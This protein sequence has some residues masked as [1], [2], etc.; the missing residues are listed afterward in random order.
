M[1]KILPIKGFSE[2]Y[3]ADSGYVYSRKIYN[4]PNGRIKK[5]KTLKHNKGY[6]IIVLCKDGKTKIRYVHRLVAEAFIPNPEN[7]PEINHKNGI[8]SDNRVENLEWATHS[9]NQIHRYRVLKH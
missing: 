8:K 5:I 1:S 7:K 3:I 4:N 9:E 2:Y 6:S